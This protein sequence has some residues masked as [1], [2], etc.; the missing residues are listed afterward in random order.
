MEAWEELP[1][2][3]EHLYELTP[4]DTSRVTSSHAGLVDN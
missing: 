2:R 4:E 3:C 1:L